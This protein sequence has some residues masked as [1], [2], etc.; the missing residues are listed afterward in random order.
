MNVGKCLVVRID[1]ATQ[2]CKVRF[3][4][5]KYW[6]LVKRVC[7]KLLHCCVMLLLVFEKDQS[8]VNVSGDVDTVGVSLG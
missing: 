3:R 1:G 5:K 4:L 2:E 7:K 6:W 8:V